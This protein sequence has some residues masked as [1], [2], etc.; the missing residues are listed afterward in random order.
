MAIRQG[1]WKL[2]KYAT[3][4]AG[5]KE[6]TEFSPPRL[7]DLSADIGETNDLSGKQPAKVKEL[8]ALWEAWNNTLAAPAWPQRFYAPSRPPAQR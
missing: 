6:T 5:E 4:F 7:Y 1:N 8:T 3:E 2:V